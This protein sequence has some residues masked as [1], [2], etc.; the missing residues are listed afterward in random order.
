MYHNW[1]TVIHIVYMAGR[2]GGTVFYT[3]V[4]G[5]TFRRC[6]ILNIA[7]WL[8]VS[9]WYFKTFGRWHIKYKM[10][11]C[12]YYYNVLISVMAAGCFASIRLRTQMEN[13]WHCKYHHRIVTADISE[14]NDKNVIPTDKME[15]SSQHPFKDS[16]NKTK[17][18]K[19]QKNNN[20][21]S[22]DLLPAVC[23]IWRIC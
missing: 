23:Q 19:Q 20:F 1:Y 21:F 14:C 15:Y 7:T 2:F 10:H 9:W 13:T 16:E 3:L 22:F 18:K 8:D 17:Q 12:C 6:Y 4:Y 11:Y 5:W